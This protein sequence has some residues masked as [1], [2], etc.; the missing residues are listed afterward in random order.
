M[1]CCCGLRE[2]IIIWVVYCRVGGGSFG[3]FYMCLNS[4]YITKES[5]EWCQASAVNPW[6]SILSI[7]VSYRKSRSSYT[8]VEY[9]FQFCIY[10]LRSK[11]CF[12]WKLT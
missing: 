7:V 1:Y 3:T 9:R 11:E 2:N 6:Y 12:L 4:V 8:L 10:R 5:C